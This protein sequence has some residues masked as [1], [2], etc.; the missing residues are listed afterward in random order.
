MDGKPVSAF[1]DETMIRTWLMAAV[2]AEDE[3]LKNRLAARLPAF[4]MFAVRDGYWGAQMNRA[5]MYYNQS[6][7]WFGV[8][9]Y[10]DQFKNRYADAT[11]NK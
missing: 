10:A 11:S 4:S 6:L 3:P 2:A 9:V 8:A 5:G 7:M 1:Q